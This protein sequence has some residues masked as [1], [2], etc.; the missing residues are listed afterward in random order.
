MS[1]I[2]ENPFT[3]PAHRRMMDV[4]A[5]HNHSEPELRE[6]LTRYFRQLCTRGNIDFIEEESRIQQA[7]DQAV[8]VAKSKRWLLEPETLSAELADKL[9]RK[10]KGIDYINQYLEA[11]GLPP[12]AQENELELEKARTLVKN[13][14][15]DFS[16][17]TSEE[18]LKVEAKAARFLATRGFSS[19]VVRK[20]IY[21]KL[22]D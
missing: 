14:Y 18:R 13:K 10:N 1:W 9:H 6:K 3:S 5:S 19:D 8:Q 20:V 22:G 4:L 17:L 21:E 2:T 15:S 7:I 12:V 16:E 11:R